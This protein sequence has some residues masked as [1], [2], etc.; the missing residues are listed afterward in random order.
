[1]TYLVTGEALIDFLG[2]ES[3]MGDSTFKGLNGGSSFNVAVGLARLEQSASYFTGLSNDMF[4]SQLLNALVK[5]GV[6]VEALR[7]KDNPSTLAFVTMDKHG[8]P[9]YAFYGDGAADRSLTS[10]DWSEVAKSQDDKTRFVHF[11]SYSIVAPPTSE[12]LLQVAKHF[13]DRFINL[14]PNIRPTIQ[15]DM[16]VELVDTV[17]AGDT[18]SASLLYFLGSQNDPVEFTNTASKDELEKMLTFC[19]RAAAITCS[20]AGADLPRLSELT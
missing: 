8:V 12:T 3:G 1:M 13:S 2:T 20:R 5:E 6:S 7:I 15:P 19:I 9:T 4:G 18:F 11:G 14:D 17:G 10:E 16:Q